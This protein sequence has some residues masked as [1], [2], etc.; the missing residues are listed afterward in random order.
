MENKLVETQHNLEELYSK[1]QLMPVLIDQFSELTED[2]FEREVLA[3]IYLHKQADVPTMVGL[4]SPRWGDPEDVALQLLE[5]CEQDLMDY[6]MN[7]E[8][9]SVRYGLSADVEDML[10][11]YQYP[12]PMIC[13][14]KPVTKNF[15]RTGYLTGKGSMVLNGSDVFRNEEL[16]LDH[17]NRC[18]RV[19]L[20]L[21]LDVIASPE[22]NM[23]Q[24][25]RRDGESFEDFRKRKKQAEVF[26]DTSLDVMQS[27]TALS[28]RLYL[29][30][31][32]D[33][34]GRTYACGY[35]VNS[36]GTDYN[37]AVLQLAN[38]EVIE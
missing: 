19:A 4:F 20:T 17:I 24:P 23:M 34:R 5:V 25:K 26:Y 16:C 18:N 10:A 15:G 38:K 12:M 37:K 31:K 3:Q 13:K 7:T 22:G 1:Y 30:H 9:F 2:P 6:D 32:Y 28:D 14:P 21:D 8:R 27:L 11:R 36:Q 35:H 33:R 29:T